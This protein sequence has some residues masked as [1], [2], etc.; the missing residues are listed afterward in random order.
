MW[1]TGVCRY[2]VAPRLGGC[3]ADRSFAAL[4][5]SLAQGSGLVRGQWFGVRVK[6]QSGSLWHFTLTPCPPARRIKWESADKPGSVV[7]NH[8]SGTAVTGG[9]ERP[10]RKRRGPRHRFPIWSCSRWG[11]PSRSVLPPARCAL[12]APFHPYQLPGGILSVALSVGSRPP[13][14]TWH[15]ALWSPDFPPRFAAERLPGRLP[16]SLSHERR[17]SCS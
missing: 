11:L 12:T 1:R 5:A 3:P 4:R 6:C 15:P 17:S 14:I 9:L 16:T 8:S 10:T 2:V 13:G 7:G